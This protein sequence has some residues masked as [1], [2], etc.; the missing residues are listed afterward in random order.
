MGPSIS[1][2]FKTA[3]RIKVRVF[4]EVGC[5]VQEAVGPVWEMTDA[6]TW[7]GA[8]GGPYHGVGG[9]VPGGPGSYTWPREA[10]LGEGPQ[11]LDDFPTNS[12]GKNDDFQKKQLFS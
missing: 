6:A 12:E 7:G 10:R 4:L 2:A 5:R 1:F 11:T 8:A 9:G 3:A